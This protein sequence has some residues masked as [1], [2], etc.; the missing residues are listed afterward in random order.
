ML[1][2]NA[3]VGDV[4]NQTYPEEFKSF[5]KSYKFSSQFRPLTPKEEEENHLGIRRG[6]EGI[7]RGRCKLL[8]TDGLLVF[9]T[10]ERDETVLTGR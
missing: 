2:R 10:D 6:G 1:N 9:S 3:Q 5:S 8:G 7:D 4:Q